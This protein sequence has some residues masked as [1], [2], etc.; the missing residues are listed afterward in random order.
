MQFWPQN[1]T[2]RMQELLKA[3]F[4]Y[5]WKKFNFDHK[6]DF[7]NFWIKINIFLLLLKNIQ[8]LLD[9][10]VEYIASLTS[11]NFSPCFTMFYSSKIGNVFRVG[12]H[13]SRH[14]EW[15]LVRHKGR[16]LVKHVV[17]QMVRQVV[18]LSKGPFIYL[19]PWL[20]MSYA[21]QEHFLEN[22]PSFLIAKLSKLQFTLLS[23]SRSSSWSRSYQK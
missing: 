13:V 1:R 8:N 16:H 19:W 9:Q 4:C 20:W 15:H 2:R 11:Y 22:L 10:I 3:S 23:R 12:R 18:F 17:R 7:K 5:F 6:W 14:V 21:G